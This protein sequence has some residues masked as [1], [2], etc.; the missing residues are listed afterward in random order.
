M[1]KLSDFYNIRGYIIDELAKR[2]G[3][4]KEDEKVT[5][6]GDKYEGPL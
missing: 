2:A 6:E 5:R 1:K 4:K 3:I